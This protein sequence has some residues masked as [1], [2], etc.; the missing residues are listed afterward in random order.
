MERSG[1]DIT[2]L[3]TDELFEII[4]MEVGERVATIFRD[5]GVNGIGL[6]QLTDEEAKEIFPILGDRLSVRAFLKKS[7]ARSSPSQQVS[8]LKRT[9]F[10]EFESPFNT[11]CCQC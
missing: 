5:N 2:T 7:M 9:T 8:S 10:K 6:L 4:L 3:N 11:G 1:R